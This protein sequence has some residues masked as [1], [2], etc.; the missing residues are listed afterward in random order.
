[1]AGDDRDWVGRSSAHGWINLLHSP[2]HRFD[3]LIFKQNFC[4]RGSVES[5][6]I[7]AQR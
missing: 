1:M 3:T 5:P 7:V 2:S 6:V 4:E